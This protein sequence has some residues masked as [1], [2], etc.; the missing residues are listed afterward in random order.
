MKA[1]IPF[2]K[3]D[4][5]TVKQV[6]GPSVV[7]PYNISEKQRVKRLWIGHFWGNDAITSANAAHKTLAANGLG[8]SFAADVA[9][10]GTISTYKNPTTYFPALHRNM[11]LLSISFGG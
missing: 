1:S 3:I 8:L 4:F 2:Q 10:N 11:T 5:L 9:G 6:F 7:L